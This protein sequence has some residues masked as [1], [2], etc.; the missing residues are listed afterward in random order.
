LKHESKLELIQ[1]HNSNVPPQFLSPISSVLANNSWT[2]DPIGAILISLYIIYTWVS[3]GIE[4]VGKL[5][6]RVADEE[7]IEKVKQIADNQQGMHLDKLT[8]YHFGPKF[9]VRILIYL[10]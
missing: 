8:A 6:G 2:I 7:F 10:Y 5:V 9:L 3:M 4:E 1:D